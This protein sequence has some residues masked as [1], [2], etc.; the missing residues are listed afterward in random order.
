[1]TQK[2]L[3]EQNNKMLKAIIKRDLALTLFENRLSEFQK[4]YKEKAEKGITLQIP[5]EL[6]Q[7]YNRVGEA[8]MDMA[9]SAD[10]LETIAEVARIETN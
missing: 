3:I 6:E 9:D 2:Q 7:L 4:D 5:L 10:L 8:E 1:M